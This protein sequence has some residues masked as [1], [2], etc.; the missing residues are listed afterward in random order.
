VTCEIAGSAAEVNEK[1]LLRPFDL[2]LLDINLPDCRG[3]DLIELLRRNNGAAKKVAMSGNMASS[4]IAE[5]QSH[6]VD[7]FYDKGD[8]S[9]ELT[10]VLDQVLSDASEVMSNKVHLMN[11]KAE[12]H[13]LSRRQLEV[14][15]Y[16]VDGLTNKDISFQQGLSQATVAFHLA[17]LRKKLNCKTS[18]EILIVARQ[19][20]IIS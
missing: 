5:L 17:E 15:H 20:G 2:V 4:L 9:E 14:L 6:G 11:E 7:G 19:R 12:A 10:R 8:S 3:V 13:H 16:L 18:R 1:L